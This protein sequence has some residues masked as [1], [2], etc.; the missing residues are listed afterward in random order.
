MHAWI[1]DTNFVSGTWVTNPAKLLLKLS[2]SSGIQTS[3]NALGHD[4]VLIIDRDLIHP[5]VLNN[6]YSADMNTYQSGNL[7]YLL[8]NLAEGKHELMIKAWDLLGNSSVDTISFE[9]PPLQKLQIRNLSIS[10]NPVDQET[11]IGFEHNLPE[12]LLNMR[13]DIIDLSGNTIRSNSMQSYVLSNKI[14]LNTSLFQLPIGQLLPGIYFVKLTISN[15]DS[16]VFLTSK[17]IKK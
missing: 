1:N 10:P 13:V 14:M 16:S 12:G 9:V 8:P 6:F 7:Q 17:M 5:I 11:Y 2:D 4:L 3:G 15:T